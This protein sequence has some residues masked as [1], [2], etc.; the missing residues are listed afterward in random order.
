MFV[1]IVDGTRPLR[2]RKAC[3]HAPGTNPTSRPISK[4]LTTYLDQDRLRVVSSWVVRKFVAAFEEDQG[5]LVF[6]A[7][8]EE[9]HS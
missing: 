7:T 5:G 3:S 2:M 9:V 4:L 8:L 6:Y 1:S